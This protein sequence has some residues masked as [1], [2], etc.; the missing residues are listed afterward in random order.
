MQMTAIGLLVYAGFSVLSALA[1]QKVSR[2]TPLTEK[3]FQGIAEAIRL[4]PSEDGW[5][6]VP[7]RPDL[8]TAIQEARDKDMPIL[9]W[10]MNGHPCGMT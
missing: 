2:S 4:K 8:G 6:A 3:S 10:M 7:W 1:Q 5:S 9:L